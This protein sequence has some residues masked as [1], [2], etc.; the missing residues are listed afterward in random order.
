MNRLRKRYLLN[1]YSLAPELISERFNR[2]YHMNLPFVR[3]EPVP[4]Q[5]VH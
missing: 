1:G 3:R 2:A 5:Y 4:V